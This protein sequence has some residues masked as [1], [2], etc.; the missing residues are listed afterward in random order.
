MD[1]QNLIEWKLK[2]YSKIKRI[3]SVIE[4]S[5]IKTQYKCKSYKQKSHNSKT[6]KANEFYIFCVN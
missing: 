6:Y 2:G 4:E 1:I 3:K 5:N